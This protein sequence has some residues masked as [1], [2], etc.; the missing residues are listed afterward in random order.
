MDQLADS[1][2]RADAAL[3]AVSLAEHLDIVRCHPGSMSR[4]GPASMTEVDLPYTNPGYRS[5]ISLRATAKKPYS[6]PWFKV[7][8][9]I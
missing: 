5:P 4:H 8:A 6:A 9:S 2:L 1:N 3:A 7:R